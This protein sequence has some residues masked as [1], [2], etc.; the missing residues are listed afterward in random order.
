MTANAAGEVRRSFSGGYSPFYQV[1][2][3]IGSLQFMALR[4]DIV[5]SGKMTVKQF[6]DAVPRENS[7]P[8]EML[9][10][11][12]AGQAIAKNYRPHWK[13]YPLP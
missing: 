6:H 13:F 10:N 11:L 2:F 7:M 1:D 8:V 12:L 4:N 9:R 5:S 3:M